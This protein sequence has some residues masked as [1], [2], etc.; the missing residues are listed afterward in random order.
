[1]T[2]NLDV[3]AVKAAVRASKRSGR[4]RPPIVR[5]SFE[6]PGL[7]ASELIIDNFAGGGGASLG[8]LWATGRSPDIAINHDPIA[9][10]MHRTNHPDTKHYIEDVWAVDPAEACAGRPVGL[11]WFSPTCTFFSKAKGTALDA[12]SIKLRG[13]AWVAVRWAT[14]VRPRI[15]CL[16]NVEEF[17]DW[18]PQHRQHSEGCLGVAC[19][20]DCSF[21]KSRAIRGRRH[22]AGCPGVACCKGC[23]IYRPIKSRRG[24]IFRAF[25]ARL[26]KLGYEVQHWI[27]RACDYG[28]PTTRRRLF[29]VARCDGRPIVKPEP[30][31]GPGRAHSHVPAAAC[32]DWSDLGTSI[33]DRKRPLKDKTLRRIAAGVRKFVLEHESPFIVPV[34]YGAKNEND[35]RGAAVDQSLGTICGHRGSHAVVSPVLLKAKTHG[36]GGNDAMAVTDPLR[37][38]TCSPRGEFAAASAILVRTAHG[39]VDA[40]GK[41]RGAGFHTMEEPLGV[42]CA[43]GTDFAVATAVLGEAIAD[44]ATVDAVA[45]P[46]LVHRSNG[47]RSG[48]SPRVYDAQKPLGTVMAKGEKFA[49][50]AALL[51]KHNGGHNDDCGAAGQEVTDPLHTVSTRD[52]KAIAAVH[53]LKLRGTSSAHLA[54]SGSSAAE[55]VPTISAQGGHIAQVAAFLVR[56]HGVASEH[57]PADPPGGLTTKDRYGLVTVTIDGSTYVVVDI[58]MRMLKPRELYLA[59]GFPATYQIDTD[60]TGRRFTRTAQVRMVGNSVPPKMAEVVAGAQLASGRAPET[61]IAA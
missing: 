44:P 41:R 36:G 21:G 31:H 14:A 32:I 48:Q 54:S 5:A 61:R 51:I 42:V 38:V 55:P 50:C 25:V 24:E 4:T 9:I 40:S 27:L 23:Q 11:A 2:R 7:L 37:T 13:L 52:S 19:Q 17:R 53:L 34:G 20:K 16:E 12:S 49:A 45:A 29:L 39:D 10:A 35:A 59:Q 22:A 57:S 26:V 33:F 28:A 58:R 1:V 6:G 15:I 60:D 18:G 56:Y 30:T 8:K 47:E 3:T 43:S 46:Y